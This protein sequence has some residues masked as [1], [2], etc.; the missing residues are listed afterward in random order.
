[1]RQPVQGL[2]L[3]LLL[4][5]LVTLPLY[6]RVLELYFSGKIPFR[7]KNFSNQNFF[8]E[9]YWADEEDGCHV[10]V[11]YTVPDRPVRSLV[12]IRGH[13]HPYFRSRH[14]VLR[15]VEPV[16]DLTEHRGVIVVIQN[17]DCQIGPRFLKQKQCCL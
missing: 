15:D 17:S 3:E 16:G 10:I 8:H 9:T 12:W 1:M 4:S 7:N 5:Q 6:V 13:D 2:K 14:D 11:F